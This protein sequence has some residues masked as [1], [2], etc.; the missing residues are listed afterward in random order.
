MDQTVW[1]YVPPRRWVTIDFVN[2]PENFPEHSEEILGYLNE[3]YLKIIIEDE[4]ETRIEKVSATNKKDWV[5]FY[6]GS[7]VRIEPIT[8]QHPTGRII[9]ECDHPEFIDGVIVNSDKTINSTFT[10]RVNTPW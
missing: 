7:F 6:A 2:T 1:V 5:S 10:W 9:F 8:F 3:C 4:G